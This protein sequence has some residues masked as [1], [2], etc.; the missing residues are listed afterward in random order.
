MFLHNANDT[1]MSLPL[2]LTLPLLKQGILVSLSFAGEVVEVSFRYCIPVSIRFDR[3]DYEAEWFI[4]AN[5]IKRVRY[6]GAGEY[7]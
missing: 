3:V 7:C 4:D 2:P 5:M 1:V 6:R